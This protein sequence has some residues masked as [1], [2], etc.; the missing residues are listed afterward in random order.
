M[1][2]VFD[3]GINTL[4]TTVGVH[5]KQYGILGMSYM[6]AVKTVEKEDEGKDLGSVYSVKY[7][8]GAYIL[9]AISA[10]IVLGIS[11]GYEIYRRKKQ[12]KN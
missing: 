1:S 7:T 2:Y 11:L 4:P 6:E 3:D 10:T 8:N 5:S 12:N 9:P